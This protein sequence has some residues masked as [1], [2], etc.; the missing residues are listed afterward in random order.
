MMLKFCS[1]LFL[2]IVLLLSLKHC[3]KKMDIFEMVILFM[4]TSYSIQMLFYTLS[5]PYERFRVV[6]EHLPFWAIRIQYGVIFPVLLIWVLYFLRC[7]HSLSFKLFISF[8]WVVGVV[9]M[10]RILLEMGLMESK[11]ESWYPS[12]ELVVAML[13]LIISTKFMELLQVILKKENITQ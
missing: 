8:T 3:R 4:F 5:S 9:L 7:N 11:S 13:N 10:E 6:E 2:S 1:I 12:I